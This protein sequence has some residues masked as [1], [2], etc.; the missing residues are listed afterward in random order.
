VVNNRF[1][2]VNPDS[3][4]TKASPDYRFTVAP[5]ETVTVKLRLT[6]Q[7]WPSSND[8]LNGEFDR[9]FLTRKL[10]AD[11]FYARIIPSDLTE[12]AKNVMRQSL[13]GLLWSKQFYHYV[14]REWLEGDPAAP[15]PPAERKNGRNRRVCLRG[16]AVCE[17][18]I[19]G[20]AH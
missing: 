10:E 12:D 19:S 15:P 1:D 3:E 9:V 14:Q 4:G 5:G 11:G 7:Q 6:D 13:A 17:R 18:E 16:Q 20:G 2:A 8:P